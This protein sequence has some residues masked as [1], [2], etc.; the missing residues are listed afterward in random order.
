MLSAHRNSTQSKLEADAALI[1]EVLLRAGTRSSVFLHRGMMTFKCHVIMKD[2][3]EV[4][5]RFYPTGRSDVIFQEPDLLARCR[6]YSL[7]VPTV[8]GDS[9]TTPLGSLAYIAYYRMPGETLKD[10][11]PKLERP[12]WSSAAKSLACHISSLSQLT[13]DGAGELKSGESAHT[14][15]WTDFVER[16][17]DAGSTAVREHKL[18]P[19][20]LTKSLDRVLKQG[21]PATYSSTNRLIWGDINFENILISD[22]LVSGLIDF[23]GCLSGDPRAT[24]GYLMAVHGPEP[25]FNEVLRGWPYEIQ[26]DDYQMFAWYALLRAMRLARFAHLPLPTGRPRDPL[27]EILPGIAP[28]LQVLDSA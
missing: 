17:M 21:N 24:I 11:L 13:F 8:I 10:A 7:P 18:L 15:S 4:M 9:R 20:G 19:P 12:L 28:A 16:C 25:F 1:A 14:S 2:G 23:E 6:S 27:I 3:R 22:G 26:S 5:V